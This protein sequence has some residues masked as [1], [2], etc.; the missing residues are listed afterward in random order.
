MTESATVLNSSSKKSVFDTYN[1]SS[2]RD[3]INSGLDDLNFLEKSGNKLLDSAKAASKLKKEF[4]NLG[5]DK[6]SDTPVFDR[7]NKS[8]SNI[9]SHANS[10]LTTEVIMLLIGIGGVLAYKKF[11]S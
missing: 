11:K 3:A 2:F 5:S 6:I 1:G 7:I 9:V 8:I 10:L 4:L